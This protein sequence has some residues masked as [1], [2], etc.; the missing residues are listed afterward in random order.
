[1][2]IILL[3]TLR[4]TIITVANDIIVYTLLLSMAVLRE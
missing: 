2:I 1:M 4:M 3:Y